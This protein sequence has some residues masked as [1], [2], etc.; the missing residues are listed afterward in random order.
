MLKSRAPPPKPQLHRPRAAD[1]RKR[2]MMDLL[3]WSYLALRVKS[4]PTYYDI[5]PGH[6]EEGVSRLV[7]EWY[8]GNEFGSPMGMD[9]L[10]ASG[11]SGKMSSGVRTPEVGVEV[12]AEEKVG[13][14]DG[15]T[16]DPAT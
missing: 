4:N 5:Y 10:N 2:D 14:M 13:E 1:L 6:E 9:K 7:D 8:V 15:E 16:M 3:S 12:V 11:S